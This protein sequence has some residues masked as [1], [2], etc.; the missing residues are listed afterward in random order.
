MPENLAALVRFVEERIAEDES[1]AQAATPGPWLA[2]PN[3]SIVG[4]SGHLPKLAGH[5]VCSV[6]AW[7][8]G[9]PTPQ[10]AAHIAR[11]DPARV[12]RD[13]AAK[14]QLLRFYDDLSA[15]V[16]ECSGLLIG[17]GMRRIHAEHGRLLAAMAAVWCRHPDF[18]PEWLPEE[19]G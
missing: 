14:R 7:D 10:D 2:E 13:V 9:R 19:A 4:P 18:Q 15:I 12:L 8:V 16:V 1:T 6:G 11:N 5:V 17:P 3:G